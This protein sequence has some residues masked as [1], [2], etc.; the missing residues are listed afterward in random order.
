MSKVKE[1]IR[2]KWWNTGTQPCSSKLLCLFFFLNSKYSV[3]FLHEKKTFSASAGCSWQGFRLSPWG[4]GSQ[5]ADRHLA[6]AFGTL[7]GRNLEISWTERVNGREVR[8]WRTQ[9]KVLMDLFA[10]WD[11]W[12]K[13]AR[14]PHSKGKAAQAQKVDWCSNGEGVRKP[15]RETCLGLQNSF[16]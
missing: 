10:R 14:I 8:H 5:S 15:W 3:H 7:S 13:L 12:K 16:P 6:K 11:S 9:E 2:N 4:Q 1:K